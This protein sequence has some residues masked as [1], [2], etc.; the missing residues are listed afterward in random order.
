MHNALRAFFAAVFGIAALVAWSTP[1]LA[2][3]TPVSL[4]CQGGDDM[5]YQASA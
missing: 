5:L 3:H 2:T 1:F 4:A